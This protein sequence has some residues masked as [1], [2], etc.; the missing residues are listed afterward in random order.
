VGLG[1]GVALPVPVGDAEGDNVPCGL[2]ESTSKETSSNSIARQIVKK[3]A[4]VSQN[5]SPPA[6]CQWSTTSSTS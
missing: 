5:L 6:P 2:A 3:N 1:V 4:C